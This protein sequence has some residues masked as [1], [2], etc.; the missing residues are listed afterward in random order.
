M[1]RT[2]SATVLAGSAEAVYTVLVA[3]S[4]GLEVGETDAAL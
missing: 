3:V 1:K 2:G 4:V